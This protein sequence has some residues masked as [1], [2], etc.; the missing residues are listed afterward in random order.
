MAMAER[1]A[2]EARPSGRRFCVLASPIDGSQRALVDNESCGCLLVAY[3]PLA[4]TCGL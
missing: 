2:A 1:A 3:R 4:H